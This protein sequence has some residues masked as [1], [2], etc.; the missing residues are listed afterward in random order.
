MEH[1]AILSYM[2]FFDP[3]E[4]G[5]FSVIIFIRSVSRMSVQEGQFLGGIKGSW[6]ETLGTGSSL[7]WWMIFF[8]PMKDTLEVLC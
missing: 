4:D 8:D 7:M 1:R 5:P 6:P 3:K 2:I